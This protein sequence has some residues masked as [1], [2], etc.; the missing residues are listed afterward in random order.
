MQLWCQLLLAT[1]YA[2][3]ICVPQVYKPIKSMFY[4]SY[5]Q[6]VAYENRKFRRAL[7]QAG[8]LQTEIVCNDSLLQFSFKDVCVLLIDN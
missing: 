8:V 1:L 4:N 3:C 6:G 7:Y 2:K 5:I